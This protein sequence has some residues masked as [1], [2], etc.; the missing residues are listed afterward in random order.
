MASIRVCTATLAALENSS[1]SANNV[2]CLALSADSAS[3]EG[4]SI[5]IA[6][7]LTR[8]VSF[9]LVSNRVLELPSN[10]V[11]SKISHARSRRH[12]G[13]ASSLE[14]SDGQSLDELAKQADRQACALLPHG[15]SPD[16]LDPQ[17]AMTALCVQRGHIRPMNARR[18]SYADAYSEDD[19]GAA[20]PMPV[21]G[22]LKPFTPSPVNLEFLIHGLPESMLDDS[23]DDNAPEPIESRTKLK[24]GDSKPK[25]T[26]KKK[27]SRGKSGAVAKGKQRQKHGVTLP[28][29]VPLPRPIPITTQM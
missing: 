5:P 22:V 4:I 11:M 20:L 7:K 18:P 23:D 28:S 2:D 8:R 27:K 13:F 14:G 9:N 24:N 10:T 25:R 3:R 19:N 16:L 26:C 17:C 21:K 29:A 1:F 6:S 12:S 15:A